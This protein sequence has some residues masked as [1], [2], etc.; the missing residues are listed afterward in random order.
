MGS[1]SVW[2]PFD[3]HAFSN[4]AVVDAILDAMVRF[5]NKML[6]IRPT[7]Y[8]VHNR[9]VIDAAADPPPVQLVCASCLQPTGTATVLCPACRRPSPRLVCG[10]PIVESLTHAVLATHDLSSEHV[11][12]VDT[13][14]QIGSFALQSQELAESLI[15]TADACSAQSDSTNAVIARK[16]VECVRSYKMR[17]G[18][19][20]LVPLAGVGVD[21]VGG[22]GHSLR[23][24][25]E[26]WAREFLYGVDR[27]VVS[28]FDLIALGCSGD[29]ALVE[30][31]INRLAHLV[32]NRVAC[33]DDPD[34]VERLCPDYLLHECRTFVVDNERRATARKERDRKALIAI[35]HLALHGTD[36]RGIVLLEE[37][38]K[39]I[40][41]ALEHPPP[42]ML[43]CDEKIA[44]KLHFDQ[45][46]DE[47]A[48]A[49]YDL[50]LCQ[51]ILDVWRMRCNHGQIVAGAVTNAL[52]RMDAEISSPELLQ[53][54]CRKLLV[55][56]TSEHA[57]PVPYWM[58]SHQRWCLA[59][60]S[61]VRN[62]RIDLDARGIRVV[63]ICTL[64]GK[65]CADVDGLPPGVVK[66]TVL[67]RVAVLERQQAQ[68]VALSVNSVVK[69]MQRGIE[70]VR[71]RLALFRPEQ[72]HVE[73]DI[74]DAMSELSMFSLQMVNTIFSSVSRTYERALEH[75]DTKLREDKI[76]Q[77]RG[78]E[79][80]DIARMALSILLPVFSRARLRPHV[81]DR[82]RFHP[83]ADLLRSVPKVRE[84]KPSD[85][86]LMLTRE[87]LAMGAGSLP[88]VL[89]KY[90]DS[91]KLVR[92]RRTKYGGRWEFLT[93]D[94]TRVMSGF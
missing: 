17:I 24:T 27:V 43:H 22:I 87:E 85:G 55:S 77:T 16:L 83:M 86:C 35:H 3:L 12:L 33:V 54:V 42:E 49:R 1:Q 62:S 51:R 2:V 8:V 34:D 20:R 94:L 69:P 78:N 30:A 73:R 9:L 38:M 31:K 6:R 84:W 93:R 39:L 75:I 64:L 46:V 59:V 32:A 60:P 41:D 91:G 92:Y 61:S 11:E 14:V 90:W 67:R 76:T 82:M 58:H 45:L 23:D 50:H 80:V 57:F 52:R 70:F 13:L 29:C 25:I 19:R 71:A 28:A 10:P 26:P 65:M 40:V 4:P 21:L 66:P 79:H 47:F 53:N 63:M 7:L 36:E 48:A 18:L 74:A 68:A 44:L 88:G 5:L 81:S 72:S 56:E 89:K 37:H 15:R